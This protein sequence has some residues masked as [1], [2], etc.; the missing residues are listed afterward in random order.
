MLLKREKVA[1][2]RHPSKNKHTKLAPLSADIHHAESDASLGSQARRCG[3]TTMDWLYKYA[4]DI[5]LNIWRINS[6]A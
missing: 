2:L 4:I 6:P 5:A 1:R 3:N